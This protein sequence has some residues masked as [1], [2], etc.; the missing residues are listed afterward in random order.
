MIVAKIKAAYIVIFSMLVFISS[1]CSSPSR[2]ELPSGIVTDF[3]RACGPVKDVRAHSRLLQV[4]LTDNC[5]ALIDYFTLNEGGS[6][7]QFIA[8]SNLALSDNYHPFLGLKHVRCQLTARYV[9]FVELGEIPQEEFDEWLND[10]DAIIAF[11]G[12]RER[13]NGDIFPLETACSIQ[14]PNEAP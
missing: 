4:A 9:Q 6:V 5:A 7:E 1:G 3:N 10:L 8:F 14:A 12:P 11:D 13:P 2:I